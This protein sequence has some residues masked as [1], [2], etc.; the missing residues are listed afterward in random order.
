M[1]NTA[2][3]MLKLK[4]IKAANPCRHNCAVDFVVS[5]PLGL[6]EHPLQLQRVAQHSKRAETRKM[7][8]ELE[9]CQLAGWGFVPAGFTP[10]GSPGPAAKQLLHEVGRRATADLAGWPKSV[11]LVKLEQAWSLALAHASSACVPGCKKPS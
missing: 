7:K 10:W 2:K 4:P 5:H 3:I 11:K 6:A 1:V 9:L 8:K